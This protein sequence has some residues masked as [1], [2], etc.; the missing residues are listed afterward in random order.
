ML[1]TVPLSLSSPLVDPSGELRLHGPRA[2]RQ[3]PLRLL[4]PR[5]A[6]GHLPGPG[7]GGHCQSHALELRLHR[8]FWGELRGKWRWCVHS[9]VSG[10][11]WVSL[12]TFTRASQGSFYMNL[13]VVFAT[14]RKS[15]FVN[16]WQGFSVTGRAF[17]TLKYVFFK[18]HPK[19][20]SNYINTWEL[21]RKRQDYSNMLECKSWLTSDE[22]NIKRSL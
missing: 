21:F 5:G 7:H 10:G 18:Q 16:H 8:G 19:I 1:F 9:E 12:Q 22:H 3:H 4:L 11:R 13:R 15:H 6:P 20:N 2:Q 17:G 14:V